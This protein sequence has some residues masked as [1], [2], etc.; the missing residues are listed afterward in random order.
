MGESAT[1]PAS[2]RPYGRARGF[3]GAFALLGTLALASCGGGQSQD[4]T[5][6]VGNYQVSVTKA[7]FPSRQQ[8]SE[9]TDLQLAIKNTGDKAIPNLAITIFTGTG[10]HPEADGSFSTRVD[11]PTLA[12]PSRPV[13]I[14]ENDYPKLLGPGVTLANLDKQPPAGAAAAQ[15]DTYQFG[16]LDPGEE[17]AV[18]WRVT[19][20]K[21]GTFT[22]QYQV[23]AGLQGNAKAVTADGG[24]VNGRFTVTVASKPP[25]TCVTGSGKIVQGRCQLGPNGSSG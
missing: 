22:V 17:K 15:T 7:S 2:Q 9:T 16:P 24:P 10:P 18:V 3:L 4:A 23:A 21:A 25:Q 5:E 13:W 20:A 14:L 12:N 6:P 19:P 8:L 11:D 1:S